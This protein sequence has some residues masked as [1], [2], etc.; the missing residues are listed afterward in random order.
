MLRSLLFTPG[1]HG[2]RVEKALNEYSADAAILDLEDAVAISEKEAARTSIQEALTRPH[3]AK[4][5]VR[6]N[7]LETPWFF[8]DLDAVVQTGLDGIVLPKADGPLP[9]QVADQY[10]SHLERQRG[11]PIGRLDLIPLV[12]S[13]TGMVN[14]A[15]IARSGL[16]R[17]RRLAFGAADFTLDA[18]FT[19]TTEE[20]ELLV[21]RTQLAV[22]SRSAG[23]EPPIETVFL[24][25]Q[26]VTGLERS[27]TRS[28]ELGFQG[29][30]CIHPNQVAVANRLYAPSP[31]EISWAREVAD[32]FTAAE[33]E[34][35]ASIQVRGQLV[36]YPVAERARQLLRRA[37]LVDE[38]G[39]S[40][41]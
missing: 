19:W 10:M 41:T 3:T 37:G 26:D 28:R 18:G 12:E 16:A 34:G 14:L 4:A 13:A 20:T 15:E 36:D 17:V 21:L 9:L 29:R 6:I 1:N 11:L 39:R 5:Y 23:L 30:L 2:R 40:S 7:S 22:L 33:R 38:D 25:I 8:G 27:C 32:A 24:Q 35:V 31:A